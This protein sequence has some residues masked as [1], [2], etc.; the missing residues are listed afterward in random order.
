MMSGEQRRLAAV[1]FT[2]IVGYSSLTQ[3]NERLALELLEEHRR[4]VRPIVS[5]HN[6]QEIKTIGDAFLIEFPSALEATECAVEV[7]RSLHDYNQQSTADRRVHIRIGIH[8]GDVI[9][10]QNDVLGD[11][12]NI[13]SR[14]E[15]LAEPDGICISEQV[16]DQVRN[17]IS[18]MTQ[19]LGPRQLKNISY[20][21]DVHRILW[22]S[23]TAKLSLDKK[24]I[25]VLPFA[26]MSP[27]P[28]DEYFAD[29]MTEELI[30]RLAHVK[31]LK[32]IARTSVM[33]YKKKEKKVSEIA[34]ELEVG[35]LVEGSVRKA[36]NRIRVTVQLISAGTEEHLWSSHYDKTLDD[37]FV[38][39]SEIA[40]KVAGELET[41]LLDSEKQTLEKKPTEN[42]EAYACFLQGRE[43][44]RKGTE[45]SLKQA[46]GL[47]EKAIKLDSSFAK[48]YVGTADCH[49]TLADG[50]YEPADIALSAVKSSLKRAIELD[51]NLPEAHA[52]L[53]NMFFTEDNVLGSETE[54]RMALEL[55]PS[56]SATHAV[57]SELAGI[58]GDSE[59]MVRQIE[60]AY[61]LD[62]IRP[63]FIWVLGVTYLWIGR[64][65]EA[66]ELWKKT[67][68]LAPAYI[69]RGMTEHYLIKGDLEKAKEFYA[70]AEKLEP[71]NSRVIWMGGVIAAMEGDR[72]RAQLVIRRI[73][74]TKMGPVGFNFI[75]YVYHALG[76]LDS[77]FEYMNRT[78]EAHTIVASTLMY[79]P[80]FAKAR[81][82]PRYLDLVEKLRRQCGLIK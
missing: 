54:A 67:E 75:G 72:E 30:D 20:A 4:I 81:N 45:T 76:D 31:S 79:S 10:R 5:R 17:K 74:D 82:D 38:V 37:I 49:T 26:N 11:A 64:E 22:E 35:T 44:F 60:I 51:P 19:N 48:A 8:L 18:Y 29:G 66:L 70:K 58:K 16:F 3:K 47:F 28:A 62:P 63:R 13:A 52:A 69:Y 80:L 24:R 46:I 7:Q 32:V 43:L 39:Q 36:G 56:L 9:Q 41:Q 61:R 34:R 40:E 77:Y 1:M 57:L 53:A 73:E 2:D 78:A 25:A 15:P 68:Q 71:T 27:D 6:G 14:V 21:I 55:D 42:T 50:G 65:Q 23:E 33:S 12:V 59:E